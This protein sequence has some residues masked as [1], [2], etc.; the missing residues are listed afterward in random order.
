V[1]EILYHKCAAQGFHVGKYSNYLI[2]AN[3]SASDTYLKI[4]NIFVIA[5]FACST[6]VCELFADCHGFIPSAHLLQ[7]IYEIYII[8]RSIMC[9]AVL[10]QPWGLHS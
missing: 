7:K 4:L 8:T 3:F 10:H 2:L 5:D 1:N 6:V 9:T